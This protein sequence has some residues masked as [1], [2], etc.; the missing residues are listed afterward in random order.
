MLP[1]T[2]AEQGQ[3]MCRDMSGDGTRIVGYNAFFFQEGTGFVW[4][5]NRA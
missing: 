3:A 4:T 2:F 5:L 1:G